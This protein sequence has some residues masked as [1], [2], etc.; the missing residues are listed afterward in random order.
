L[1]SV[2]IDIISKY[3]MKTY[4]NLFRSNLTVCCLYL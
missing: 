4:T 1:Q 2:L 3:I